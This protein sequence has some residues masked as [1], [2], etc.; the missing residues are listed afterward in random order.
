MCPYD[1]ELIKQNVDA[2]LPLFSVKVPAVD[3][4]KA[5]LFITEFV[6]SIVPNLCDYL[7]DDLK[8]PVDKL[9]QEVGN[10]VGSIY[11][12]LEKKFVD[13]FNKSSSYFFVF[14]NNKQISDNTFNHP[15]LPSNNDIKNVLE[16]FIIILKKDDLQSR[17]FTVYNEVNKKITFGTAWANLSI[18]ESFNLSLDPELAKVLL[19]VIKE[20]PIKEYYIPYEMIGVTSRN[21]KIIYTSLFSKSG[22]FGMPLVIAEVE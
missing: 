8:L 13:Y 12:V 9:F 20:E 14:S 7:Y 18:N 16:E 2:L 22:T 4:D 5:K 3:A 21:E 6:T 15:T 10:E 17:G 1:K 19:K 11:S